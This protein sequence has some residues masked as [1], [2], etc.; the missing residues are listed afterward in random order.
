MAG[1]SKGE[2]W[3][4]SAWRA[5]RVAEVD[6]E[7]V[8]L[9]RGAGGLRLR[10]GEVL[11]AL[12]SKGGVEAL[13]FSSMGAY[14]VER[15]GLGARWVSDTRTVARRL[16]ELPRLRR[17][18]ASGEV[19]WCMANEVARAATAESEAFLLALAKR[20]TVRRMKKLLTAANIPAS[21]GRARGEGACEAAAKRGPAQGGDACPLPE[22]REGIK[23][24]A[25][26]EVALLF[27]HMRE[28]AEMVVGSGD[29]DTILEAMLAE[30]MTALGEHM[31]EVP[32]PYVRKCREPRDE[33]A[34]PPWVPPALPVID[35][36][37]PEDARGLDAE[38]VGLAR[39]LA[40]RDLALGELTREMQE[41]CGHQEL[42]YASDRQYWEERLGLCVTSVKERQTL[43]HRVSRFPALWHAIEDGEVGLA[44]GK[45]LACI[46]TQETEQAWVGRARCRTFKH[47]REEVRAAE[48]RARLDGGVP[49]PPGE[50]T[51]PAMD[52]DPTAVRSEKMGRVAVRMWMSADLKALFFAV[53]RAWRVAGRPYGDFLR[54]LCV[55]FWKAWEHTFETD[56][57]YAHIYSRDEWQCAS[58]T[59]TRRD[60]T[61]HHLKFRSQDGGEEEENV[62]TLCSWCHLQGIHT[63]GSIK[64]RGPATEMLWRTP[65]LEVHG[66]E[67]VWRARPRSYGSAEGSVR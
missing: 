5:S 49:G 42:G 67:V 53:E 60:V 48:V 31:G 1:G 24:T 22:R 58:P 51:I 12:G 56:V 4:H 47:L 20:T 25:D 55:A 11:E 44:A 18:L 61:P 2:V 27:E 10:L 64:A 34:P 50:G 3:P 63:W 7:L 46:V 6:A 33:P 59:C 57:A 54:F 36:E 23:R 38:A 13:G 66:R 62:V 8:R 65:V 15:C 43:V 21:Q 37:L 9:G 16:R 29:P 32:E 17:A 19:T 39:E 14:V 35:V 41:L 28:V 40:R 52:D 30:G 45:L 26:R